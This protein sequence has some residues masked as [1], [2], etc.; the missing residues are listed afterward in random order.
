MCLTQNR[1]IRIIGLKNVRDKTVVI[2]NA[3]SS[4]TNHAIMEAAPE[5]LFDGISKSQSDIWAA[6]II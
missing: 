1:K 6:G 4:Y 3:L 2:N 5:L